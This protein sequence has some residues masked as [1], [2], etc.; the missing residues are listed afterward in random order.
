MPKSILSMFS[1]R[2]F[3]VSRLTC[4]TFKSLIHFEFIFMYGV[5][6]QTDSFMGFSG[7]SAGKESTCNVGDLPWVGKIL[8]KREW[9]LTPVFW[10]GKFHGLYSPRG[11]KKLDMIYVAVQ[12]F[13]HHLCF[14]YYLFLP[15]LS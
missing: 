10:P 1:S 8:W 6:K 13:Q 9:L 3:I 2:I 12:F 14:L 11:H 7:G 15:H 5:I 4:F